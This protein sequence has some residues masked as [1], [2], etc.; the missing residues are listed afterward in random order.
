VFFHLF[1]GVIVT[2][3]LDEQQVRGY[4]EYIAIPIKS[5][6][7]VKSFEYRMLAEKTLLRCLVE[8]LNLCLTRS[9]KIT[10]FGRE[11]GWGGTFNK[12]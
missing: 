5:T 1:H 9:V 2:T 12:R 6:K 11:F 3:R 4:A 10:L 7:V 8:R